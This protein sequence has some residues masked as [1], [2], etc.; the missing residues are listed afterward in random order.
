MFVYIKNVATM[1]QKLLGGKR[2]LFW[3]CCRLSRKLLQMV[4]KWSCHCIYDPL[5]HSTGFIF[6]HVKS[7][8]FLL[9]SKWYMQSKGA[10]PSFTSPKVLFIGQSLEILKFWKHSKLLE[11]SWPQ[12]TKETWQIKKQIKNR[13][14][15]PQ[16]TSSNSCFPIPI[17]FVSLGLSC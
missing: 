12:V 14:L 4:D 3:L 10:I 1:L 16:R 17:C 7:T 2:L 13:V 11:K 6:F 8:L 5:T 9:Y 15:L